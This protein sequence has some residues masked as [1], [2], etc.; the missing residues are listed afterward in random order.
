MLDSPPK[1]RRRWFQFSSW[2][3]LLLVTILAAWRG[4]LLPWL[5]IAVFC[6]SLALCVFCVRRVIQGRTR[7]RI[8]LPATLASFLFFYAASGGPAVLIGRSFEPCRPAAQMIYSPINFVGRT[9]VG[10]TPP[11]QVYRRYIDVWKGFADYG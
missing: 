9:L 2:T 11:W 8:M 1:T 4:F 7:R 5:A 6:G 10:V 3:M